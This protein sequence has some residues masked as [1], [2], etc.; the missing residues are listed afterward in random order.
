MAPILP[1][2]LFQ[3]FPGRYEIRVSI[4]GANTYVSQDFY[5]YGRWGWSDDNSFEVS[6][7]GNIEI[8]LDKKSYLTGETVSAFFKAHL[9]E[10]CW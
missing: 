4:P 9:V 1:T 6:N 7:E 5:S 3:E 8:E 2:H 10:E